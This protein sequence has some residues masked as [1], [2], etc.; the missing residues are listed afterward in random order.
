MPGSETKPRYQIE[1]DGDK[2]D[3]H[4]LDRS[5]GRRRRVTRYTSFKA[6]VKGISTDWAKVLRNPDHGFVIPPERQ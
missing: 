5:T 2:Y 1:K 6:A 3:L 4:Y